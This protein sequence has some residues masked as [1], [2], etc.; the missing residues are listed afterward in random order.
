[1]NFTNTL[2]WIIATVQLLH[3]N[4]FV[5]R[6]VDGCVEDAPDPHSQRLMLEVSAALDTP[7]E[8]VAIPGQMLANWAT[9]KN[10]DTRQPFDA[11]DAMRF[12]AH[13]AGGVP[14]NTEVEVTCCVDCGTE[15][16]RGVEAVV[17]F[18]MV[19]KFDYTDDPHDPRRMANCNRHH[20]IQ[21]LHRKNPKTNHEDPIWCHF[22][23]VHFHGRAPN[24]GMVLFND[25]RITVKRVGVC[26]YVEVE[27]YFLVV[28]PTF[29]PDHWRPQQ[30]PVPDV[31]DN[32]ILDAPLDEEEAL[33]GP[34][35]SVDATHVEA[36]AHAP[37]GTDVGD[38]GQ[39]ED[40]S[41][42]SIN[43]SI[44]DVVDESILDVASDGDSCIDVDFGAFDADAIVPNTDASVPS[45]PD[46]LHKWYVE[47]MQAERVPMATVLPGTIGTERNAL[48]DDVAEASAEPREEEEEEE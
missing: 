32:S 24:R 40:Y 44:P 3:H 41:V 35:A 30:E 20:V 31:V 5:L 43:E 15:V 25:D 26:K 48:P 7:P 8:R 17:P 27:C 12:L 42:I 6:H 2:C 14:L 33:M 19:P 22:R 21:A 28:E 18:F 39:D 36:H 46:W 23:Y 11:A 16:R 1:M 29:F 4:N 38:G 37:V 45:Y 10:Y 47:Q 34:D 13:A 9:A